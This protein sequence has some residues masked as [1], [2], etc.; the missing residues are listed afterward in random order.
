M[1]D[2][3]DKQIVPS[4]KRKTPKEMPRERRTADGKKRSVVRNGGKNG[5]ARPGAGRPAGSKNESTIQK[6]HALKLF[7]ER[8]YKQTDR[9]MNAQ[10]SLAYGVQHV[11]CKETE[12]LDNGKTRTTTRVVTDVDEIIQFLDDKVDTDGGKKYYYITTAVPDNKAIDSLFDRAYG[13]AQQAIDIGFDPEQVDKLSA[14]QSKIA[15]SV[16]AREDD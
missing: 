14:M 11:M 6:L 7:R 3:T 10:L 9:L 1:T 8:V 5:G 15:Q 4:S 2:E 13:K 12:T 16:M